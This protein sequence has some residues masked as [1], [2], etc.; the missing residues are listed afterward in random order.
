MR[1]LIEATFVSLDGV[2]S[3]QMGW[4]PF[5]EENR[6]HAEAKLDEVDAFL[7]GRVT[8]EQFAASFPKV[9]GNR[10]IDRI[11]ALP[12][13]VASTTLKEVGWNAT[14]LTGDIAAEITRLKQQPGKT[15]M[16]YG[17]SLFDRTLVEHGLVDEFHLWY[18]P[19]V[20][21]HGKRLFEDVNPS[22][23]KLELSDT[24]SFRNGAVLNIYLAK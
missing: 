15:I 8:Y 18:F 23:L 19:V 21:G 22:L 12:K 13:Y 10:Y 16:K 2:V 5:D 11:N 4:A 24:H 1:K 7:L 9:K 17:T 3:S 6:A 14:L 20:V